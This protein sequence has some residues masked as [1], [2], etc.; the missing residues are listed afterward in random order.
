MDSFVLITLVGNITTRK[1]MDLFVVDKLI[2]HV[3]TCSL[4]E[5]WSLATTQGRR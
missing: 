5:I 1:N 4:Q 2:L 3:H